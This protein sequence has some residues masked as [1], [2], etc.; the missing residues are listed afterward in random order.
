MAAPRSVE[1]GIVFET[2]QHRPLLAVAATVVVTLG[3]LA[4]PP[5]VPKNPATITIDV[6]PGAVS[7]GGRAEVTLRLEAKE[8]IKIARYP[9]IKLQVPAQ[10]GLVGE[11]ETRIGSSKPPPPDKLSTNYWG[12]V[13]P[14][15]L[16]LELDE[17]ATPGAYEIEAK[18]TYFFCVSGDFCAPARVPVKIPLA[19]E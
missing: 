12:E 1:L 10:D 3:L 14:V 8:G 19:V 16:T 13:D 17:A 7:A 11:A 4:A 5:R 6:A 18:L 2:S 9:Q 15:T